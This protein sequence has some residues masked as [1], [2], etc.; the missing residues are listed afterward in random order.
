MATYRQSAKNF[1]NFFPPQV[2]GGTFEPKV[3]VLKKSFSLPSIV[4]GPNGA[5]LT[6]L[7]SASDS[8]MGSRRIFAKGN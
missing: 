7:F 2:L 5:Y 6:K 8:Q 1:L 4:N 3:R